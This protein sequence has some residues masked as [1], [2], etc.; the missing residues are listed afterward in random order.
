MSTYNNDPVS[1]CCI[2]PL[3]E[4]IIFCFLFLKLTQN[5][6]CTSFKRIHTNSICGEVGFAIPSWM[7]INDKVAYLW[8]TALLK[9][10]KN[11][12]L[13]SRKQF[14]VNPYLILF[15]TEKKLFSV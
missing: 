5:C 15:V 6:D 4:L 11:V 3:T 8:T 10:I 7:C 9:D 2:F 12:I 14:T 1:D 13:D